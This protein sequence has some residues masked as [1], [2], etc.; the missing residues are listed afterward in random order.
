MAFKLKAESGQ[1][2]PK[3]DANGMISRGLWRHRPVFYA[4]DFINHM[5]LADA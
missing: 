5:D 2:Q 4:E 3:S 1:R